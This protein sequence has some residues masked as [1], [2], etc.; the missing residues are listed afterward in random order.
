M[1][2]TTTNKRSTRRV[3]MR[4]SGRLHELGTGLGRGTREVLVER[5]S[6]STTGFV[7]RHFRSQSL[8][9]PV[10]IDVSVVRAMAS[11]LCAENPRLG[12][13][14]G[15]EEPAGT[16][17]P[18]SVVSPRHSCPRKTHVILSHPPT[19]KGETTPRAC[20]SL[21]RSEAPSG[22]ATCSAGIHRACGRPDEVRPT[23]ELRPPCLGP[24]HRSSYRAV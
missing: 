4:H 5:H 1:K 10:R 17:R 19:R 13:P 12:G 15:V 14:G 9:T 16:G 23:L 8:D 22:L 7:L 24:D 21:P 20:R 18:C 6:D 3:G 11:S 2:E